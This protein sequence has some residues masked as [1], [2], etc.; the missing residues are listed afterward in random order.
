MADP[1][2]FL[3]LA[4]TWVVIEGDSLFQQ[5]LFGEEIEE[6]APISSNLRV[7]EK[8]PLLGRRPDVH[9]GS[10]KVYECV[11]SSSGR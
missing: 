8:K 10:H 6:I 7:L 9:T 3:M 1:R 11:G 2:Q 4:M 5:F